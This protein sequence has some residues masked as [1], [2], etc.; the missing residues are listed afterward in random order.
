MSKGGLETDVV[1]FFGRGDYGSTI[2]AQTNA[3][4]QS[5]D[6]FEAQRSYFEMYLF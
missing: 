5:V 6:A 3:T 1:K 4:K 2:L